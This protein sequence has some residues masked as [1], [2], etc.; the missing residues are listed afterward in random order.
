MPLTICM[1][2]LSLGSSGM[3]KDLNTNSNDKV[4]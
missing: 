2:E 1:L 4:L 3:S